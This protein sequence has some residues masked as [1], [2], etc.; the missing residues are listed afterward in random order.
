MLQAYL[1]Y[2]TESLAQ[3]RYYFAKVF[4]VVVILNVP[5]A[6]ATFE[7]VNINKFIYFLNICINVEHVRH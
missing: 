2:K 3:F 7:F 5:R 4:N 1:V 6:V